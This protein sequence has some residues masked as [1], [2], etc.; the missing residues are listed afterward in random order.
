MDEAYAVGELPHWICCQLGAREHYAIPAYFYQRE[1]LTALFTDAWVRPNS[2]SNG[3][4]FSPFKSLRDRFDPRLRDA[5]IYDFKASLIGFEIGARFATSKDWNLILARNSWFQDR[6]VLHLNKR[7][8][9]R[10]RGNRG[11]PV[12][13]A[14]SYAARRIFEVARA[15]GCRTV[16]GQIDPGP[17]EEQLVA[18]LYQKYPNLKPEW[19]PAPKEYW[20]EWRD[21]LELADHIVVNSQWSRNALVTCGVRA[22]KLCI[23]PLAFEAE[24]AHQNPIKERTYPAAFTPNRPLNVLFLG[25]LILRKGIAEMLEAADLLRSSPVSFWFIGAPGVTP[26]PRSV[27]TPRIKW[28]GSVPR[29]SVHDYY[30]K[31]DVFI[32]PTHSDGFGL[33]QLEAQALGLPVIASK[34]CG[35]VVQHG[36]NGLLLS[37]VAAKPIADAIQ[38]ILEH[39]NSLPGMSQRAILYSTRFRPD[40]ILKG[41]DECTSRRESKVTEAK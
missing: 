32:L 3:L 17:Y 35:T 11:T 30:R 36:E 25:S 21:E 12:V 2:I 16:L 15:A 39:P 40:V 29:S 26:P 37:E 28:L 8:L 5:P 23:V 19:D 27:K 33:T 31:A 10:P 4:N 1:R 6:A 9:L 18:A 22:D 41:L 34:N 20:Q 24:T 14:Y 13:F 7:S 38:W